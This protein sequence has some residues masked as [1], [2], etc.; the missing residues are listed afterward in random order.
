MGRLTAYCREI[1]LNIRS[2]LREPLLHFLLIGLALFVLYGL[3]SPGDA[4]SKRIVV[5]Q[6]RVDDMSAQFKALWGRPPSAAELNGLVDGFVRD[7]IVF[8]EGLSL[9]LDKDDAVIKRRVRQKYDLMAEEET[10]RR[11]P[12]DADLEAWL[13]AHPQSFMRPAVVSFDQIHFDPA[14]AT[15]SSVAAAKAEL[16]RGADPGQFGQ[17]SMLPGRVNATALDLVARDFGEDFARQ[18]GTAPI[19]QWVGP[20]ESG[21]GVHL[22]RVDARAAPQLPPLADIR[23]EVAREWENDQRIR[24][25]ADVLTRLR[26]DYDIVI[27]AKL[28]GATKP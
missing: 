13:K 19:G 14:V 20:L 4:G 9:G 24:A 5:S 18:V 16:L 3:V 21:M 23:T 28:P 2:I 12:T 6:A 7:E 17:P 26:K 22:L 27:E 8:R 10:A 11:T 1:F 15:P 25:R